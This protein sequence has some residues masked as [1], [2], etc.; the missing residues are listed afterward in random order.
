MIM[1]FL[2]IL[3]LL[4]VVIGFTGL[5]LWTYSPRNK[6]RFEAGSRLPLDSPV[7]GDKPDLSERD[8]R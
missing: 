8:E 3:G 7:D 1:Q 6:A 5:V 2:Q 4:V